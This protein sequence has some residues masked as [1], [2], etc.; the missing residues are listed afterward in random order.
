MRFDAVGFNVGGAH[1]P[2]Q[3]RVGFEPD[4]RRVWETDPSVHDRDVVGEPPEWFKHSGIGFIPTQ[5]QPRRDVQ[6]ELMPAVRDRAATRPSAG[7]EHV[8]DPYV[9]DD[10]VTQD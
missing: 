5:L 8:E 10:A 9:F 6:R 7:L 3:A 2:E 1:R 4:A